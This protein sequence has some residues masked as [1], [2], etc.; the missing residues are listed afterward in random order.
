MCTHI[1]KWLKSCVTCHGTYH[2]GAKEMLD[3]TPH[4]LSSQSTQTRRDGESLSQYCEKESLAFLSQNTRVIN[5]TTLQSTHN[6]RL[7]GAPS[8]ACE[9]VG[10]SFASRAPVS[11]LPSQSAQLD[12]AIAANLKCLLRD[13]LQLQTQRLLR[14]HLQVCM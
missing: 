9:S 6:Q 5:R 14:A 10:A 11:R 4:R 12:V 2:S 1:H 8:A 3:E 13:P 7:N